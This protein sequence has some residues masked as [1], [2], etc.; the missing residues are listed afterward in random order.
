VSFDE[1]VAER[2]R[3]IVHRKPG[4][5]EKKMFGG[6]AFLFGG[7]MAVAASGGG[8]LMLRIDPERSDELLADAA[9]HPFEMRGKPA[10]GWLRIDTDGMDD[11]AFERWVGLGV[12]YAQSLPAKSS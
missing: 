10:T 12:A 6:L 1:D 11:G 8:G 4:V 5:T 3:S 9:A 7:H 2:I